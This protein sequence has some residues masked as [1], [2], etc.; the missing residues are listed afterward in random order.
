MIAS[1]CRA[2]AVN[3]PHVLPFIAQG[4][5]SSNSVAEYAI[6]RVRISWLIITETRSLGAAGLRRLLLGL[7][8]VRVRSSTSVRVG[9]MTGE[10]VVTLGGSPLT[11][12]LNPSPAGQFMD[13]ATEGLHIVTP[14][15]TPLTVCWPV[16]ACSS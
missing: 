1:R 16:G 9:K 7:T 11:M 2:G 5:A 12:S 3:A 10:P 15:L 8:P 14:R 4:V 6:H 13:T